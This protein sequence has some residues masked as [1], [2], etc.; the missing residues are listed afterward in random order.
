M[1]MR[2]DINKPALRLA[3]GQDNASSAP[4]LLRSSLLAI[5]RRRL[6]MEA[7]RV[8][9]RLPAHRL[10]LTARAFFRVQGNRQI[11]RIPTA[12]EISGATQRPP[13]HQGENRIHCKRPQFSLLEYGEAR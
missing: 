10:A 12:L 4:A 13:I 1:L 5:E 2:V 9:S 11:K 6:I 3:G 7:N 8:P